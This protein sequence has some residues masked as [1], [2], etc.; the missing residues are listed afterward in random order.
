MS[1][2]SEMIPALVA[3]ESNYMF[4][5]SRWI[6]ARASLGGN[7]KKRDF[8]EQPTQKT[9]AKR[10]LTKVILRAQC[11]NQIDCDD[12]TTDRNYVT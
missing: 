7:D 6:P 12:L 10:V 9:P 5:E 8:F 4:C 1:M 3:E 2:Y 11:T